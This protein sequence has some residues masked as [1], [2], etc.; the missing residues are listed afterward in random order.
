MKDKIR[1][2]M[3]TSDQVSAMMGKMLLQGWTMLNDTCN[4]C[5]ITPLMRSKKGEHVCVRCADERASSVQE[6]PVGTELTNAQSTHSLD[7]LLSN[8]LL[9]AIKSID[10]A[11]CARVTKLAKLI[12]LLASPKTKTEMS[13][14]WERAK[15]EY[16]IKFL[17][18]IDVEKAD[19]LVELCSIKIVK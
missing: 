9:A 2:V 5:S 11:S 15:Q 14:A 19:F 17:S 4:D 13:E 7:E 16:A 3:T 12:E 8:L 18:V 6:V 10:A 1:K